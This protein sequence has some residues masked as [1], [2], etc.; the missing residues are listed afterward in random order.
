MNTT[1]HTLIVPSGKLADAA[2]RLKANKELAER[3]KAGQP[4][5]VASS[6]DVTGLSGEQPKL[7]IQEGKLADAAAR[8][9]ANKELAERLKAGQPI[10]VASSGDVTGLSGEQPKLKI[11][12]G[13][14]ASQWYQ[15]EAWRLDAEKQA[16]AHAFPQFKLFKMDDG[17]YYWHGT[18]KPGVLDGDFTWEVAAIYNNDHPAPRMGGSVRVVLLNPDMKTLK[19]SLGWMPHHVLWCDYDGHFLCT[20]RAEDMS[21]GT[22]YETSAVQTLT[23]AIKWLAALEL[24]LTG[25]LTRELFDRKDGI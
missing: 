18:L 13:K 16:M 1:Q 24:V 11:Q 21:A 9:K 19:E 7:K 4:I 15:R 6:G 22:Q 25:N 17:R 3:L 12:E 23:W 5:E 2:A 14:L 20:T 8:L 10:E